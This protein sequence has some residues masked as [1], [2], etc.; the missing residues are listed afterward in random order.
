MQYCPLYGWSKW[1]NILFGTLISHR[2]TC[3][4]LWTVLQVWVL[5]PSPS[6]P[7]SHFQ[8]YLND[9]TSSTKGSKIYKK[10]LKKWSFKKKIRGGRKW[11]RG[12]G[13]P[14]DFLLSEISSSQNAHA[15]PTFSL[16]V[17]SMTTS[18]TSPLPLVHTK[19]GLALFV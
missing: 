7:C 13:P 11:G 5:R 19:Q 10:G 17:R 3:P 18:H 15:P 16:I 12:H 6:Y 2:K 14:A 8:W 4:Q 9:Q 1:E